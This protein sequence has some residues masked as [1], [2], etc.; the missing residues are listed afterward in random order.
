[1]PKA[2]AA[3]TPLVDVLTRKAIFAWNGGSGA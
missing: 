1:M 2:L 3:H